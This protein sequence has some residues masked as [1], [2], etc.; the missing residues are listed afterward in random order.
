MQSDY[1]NQAARQF[2]VTGPQLQEFLLRGATDPAFWIEAMG[3]TPLWDKQR[4]ICLSSRRNRTTCVPACN[5]SGKTRVVGGLV[6]WG[7]NNL[8]PYLAITTAPTERQVKYALWKEIRDFHTKSRIPLGGR[9]DL[10][11]WIISDNQRALGFATSDY[12]PNL[13]QG[14]REANNTQ[15]FMDEACGISTDVYEGAMGIAASGNATLVQTGNPVDPLTRFKE[16][17]EDPHNTTISISAYDVPNFNI[18]GHELVEY[19]FTVPERHPD[20]WRNKLGPYYDREQR[21]TQNLPTPYLTTPDFVEE[22]VRKYGLTSP[23]YISRV[24]GRFPDQSEEALFTLTEMEDAMN[25]STPEYAAMLLRAQESPLELGVD[26]AR[27]GSNS[28]VIMAWQDPVLRIMDVFSKTDTVQT[29]KRVQQCALRCAR[30]GLLPLVVKVDV[31]G[32]GGG[33][34]DYL[35]HTPFDLGRGLQQFPVVA[36]NSAS[37]ENIPEHVANVRGA[38][39][40]FAKARFED[41]SVAMPPFN[42]HPHANTLRN[43]FLTIR[44]VN[45]DSSEKTLVRGK[46]WMKTHNIPSPDLADAAVIA[47]YSGVRAR[48]DHGITI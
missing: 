25:A 46:E 20:N 8:R 23:Q 40:L 18:P 47:M 1:I 31:I 41:R 24:T 26:V 37:T 15:I 11:Q 32:V 4:Q 43:E 22:I 27:F 13:F 2:G 19:N 9:P 33:V 44:K 14:I 38:A 10:L 6:A 48:G 28:S 42:S 35:A 29:A 5:G 12:N 39:Y 34:V 21:R 7:I 17:C 3:G 30:H 36:F 45:P 16:D